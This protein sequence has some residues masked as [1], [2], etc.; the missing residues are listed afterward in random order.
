MVRRA[1][2]PSAHNKR[3]RGGRHDNGKSLVWAREPGK[4]SMGTR[5]EAG[6]MVEVAKALHLHS[7][8]Q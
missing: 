7:R 3:S 1:L 5:R 2:L 8:E 6:P 4:K